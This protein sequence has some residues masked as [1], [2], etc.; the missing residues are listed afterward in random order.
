MEFID[1][2][3]DAGW[4]FIHVILSC[5]TD[6]NVTRFQDPERLSKTTDKDPTKLIETRMEEEVGHL[7]KLAG[8]GLSG[9]FEINTTALDPKQAA[10]V[11]AEYCLDALRNH[12]WWLQLK[13]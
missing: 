10:A 7:G 11:L 6:A 12:G 1:F 4:A 9:E 3:R 5:D 2:A 13:S 8:E